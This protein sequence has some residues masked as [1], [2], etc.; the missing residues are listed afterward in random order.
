MNKI[1]IPKILQI[2]G[3]HPGDC[4]TMGSIFEIDRLLIAPDV[5]EEIV[6]SIFQDKQ[7]WITSVSTKC[8]NC[9]LSFD[10]VPIPCPASM[11]RK[12]SGDIMFTLKKNK[13][14]NVP[15]FCS[16]ECLLNHVFETVY[17]ESDRSFIL[18]MIEFMAIV[19]GVHPKSMKRGYGREDLDSFGGPHTIKK[20]K[21][22][23][24]PIYW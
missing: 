22:Q 10:S 23:V 7:T 6:P 18:K 20:F 1:K 14:G 24:T 19:F 21:N 3:V 16:F 8:V 5:R 2:K 12:K 13:F 17:N 15:T 4:V 11:Q 9:T